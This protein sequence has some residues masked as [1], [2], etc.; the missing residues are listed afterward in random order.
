MTDPREGAARASD[1]RR[2]SRLPLR[3]VY[4]TPSVVIRG[5]STELRASS[6]D[7]VAVQNLSVGSVGLVTTDRDPC[8]ARTQH[9]VLSFYL[10]QMPEG[11]QSSAPGPGHA[12]LDG[13]YELHDTV[14]TGGFAKVKVATHIQTG[15]K[16]GR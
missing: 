15:L 7:F 6:T 8:G 1:G 10:F 16:V 4:L 13:L 3:S 12:V 11:S 9:Q 5:I 2:I 14:G